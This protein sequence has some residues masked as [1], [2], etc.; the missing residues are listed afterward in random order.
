MTSSTET[1]PAVLTPGDTE[2]QTEKLLAVVKLV[3]TSTCG[4]TILL[5]TKAA[6]SVLEPMKRSQDQREM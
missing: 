1:E 4:A 6:F 5:S 2:E 3:L